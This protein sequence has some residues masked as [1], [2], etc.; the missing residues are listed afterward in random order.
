LFINTIYRTEV[1]E[2]EAIEGLLA[3][4]FDEHTL[5]E[6]DGNDLISGSR[7]AILTVTSYASCG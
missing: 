7:L 4:F 1:S 5:L 3:I 2:R 6:V